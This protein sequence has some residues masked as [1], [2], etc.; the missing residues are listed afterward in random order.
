MLNL[1]LL[2]VGSIMTIITVVLA[3]KYSKSKSKATPS[4]NLVKISAV[5]SIVVLSTSGFLTFQKYQQTVLANKETIEQQAKQKEKQK[6]Q[7]DPATTDSKAQ[8]RKV[9]QAIAVSL[10]EDQRDAKNPPFA[11]PR[12][13]YPDKIMSIEYLGNK[14]LKVQVADNF[15]QLSNEERT[16]AINYAQDCAISGF[17]MS[18][19][20]VSG[21]Q[22]DNG[23]YTTIKQGTTT[24]GHSTKENN[25]QYQWIGQ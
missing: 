9:N 7:N 19:K 8:I 14:R 6:E 2:I 18:I 21:S 23:F 4:K 24:K 11:D 17:I 10:K 20:A 13:A 22:R 25:K 5:L 15:T 1:A 3:I 16:K 12:Y